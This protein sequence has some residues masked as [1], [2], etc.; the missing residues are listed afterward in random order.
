MVEQLRASLPLK[1]S[2]AWLFF[3]SICVLFSQQ[4]F[5]QEPAIID[6]TEY[7]HFCGKV[8]IGKGEKLDLKEME[9]RLI[10]GDPKGDQI[11]IAWAN[12]PANQAS[13][14]LNSFLQ[15]RAY[16]KPQLNI[17]AGNLYVRLGPK[18]RAGAFTLKDEPPDWR[19]P[20]RRYVRGRL[21]E[22]SLLDEL[23]GWGEYQLKMNGYACGEASVLSDP[24]SGEIEVRLLPKDRLRIMQVIDESATGL[25]GGVMERYN[26]FIMG[27]FYNQRMVDLTQRRI[28]EEGVVSTI[29]FKPRCEK[30]GVVLLRRIDPGPSRQLR[31]GVGGS[32]DEGPRVRLN[33]RQTRVGSSASTA[34][35]NLDMSFEKQ[36]ATASFRWYYSRTHTRFFIEPVTEFSNITDENR[37]E[38]IFDATLF[39]GWLYN[40]RPTSLLMRVGPN[41]SENFLIEGDGPR[42][43]SLTVL[44]ADISLMDHD[45]EFFKRSPREGFHQTLDFIF[46]QNGVGSNFSAQRVRYQGQHLVNIGFFDPPMAILGFRWSVGSTFTTEGIQPQLPTR[47][48]FFG[49]GTGSLRGWESEQLPRSG[50]AFSEA[51]IGTELRFYKLLFNLVDPLVFAD[52]GRLGDIG[53]KLGAPTFFSPG[54]GLRWESPIG[55]V[56]GF[57]AQPF[58]WGIPNGESEYKQAIR[59]GV[60]LGEEF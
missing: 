40:F 53:L 60:T 19:I 1:I 11:G 7:R 18:F 24:I 13:F 28:S 2:L 17:I 38:Q 29:D 46:S 25:N 30:D 16:H 42:R 54:F 47:F 12:I 10:C 58:A 22:P 23:A 20:N 34:Q 48:Q 21:L 6:P 36:V 44:S 27:D 57:F 56:R 4:S 51:R 33:V 26:A 49:G 39:H 45:W 3:S 32:T 9:R 59:I 31:I 41:Y 35:A 15:S 55:A 43:T 52:I 50:A 5:A 14:F 8:F 37:K